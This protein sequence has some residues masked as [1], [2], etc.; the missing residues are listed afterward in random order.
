MC[1][2]ILAIKEKDNKD[3]IIN[4]EACQLFYAQHIM[5][6]TKLFLE[7]IYCADVEEIESEGDFK[8]VFK[9]SLFVD[10]V[11]SRKKI[12]FKSLDTFASEKLVSKQKV[13][14]NEPFALDMIMTFDSSDEGKTVDC[15]MLDKVETKKTSL[16][17]FGSYFAVNIVE[18]IRFYLKQKFEEVC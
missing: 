12:N 1:Q 2:D 17:M 14:K 7:E 10:T 5:E 6:S 9:V 8:R 4:E 18:A 3:A 11:N 15:N 16:S 13:E